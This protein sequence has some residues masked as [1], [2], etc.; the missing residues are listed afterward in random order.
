MS[1]RYEKSSTASITIL[2]FIFLYVPMISADRGVVQY[3]Q[4]HYASLKGFTLRQYASLFQDG[5]LS[6]AAAQ[7]PA[8]HRVL[9]SFIATVF[10]TMASLGIHN[11]ER[12][13]CARLS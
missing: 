3:R 13:D 4:G 11:H 2:I 12:P 10:G 8:R 5:T 7:L 9:A 1:S 6:D